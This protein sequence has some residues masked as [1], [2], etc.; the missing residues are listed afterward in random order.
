MIRVLDPKGCQT[1][2]YG[3]RVTEWQCQ[4]KPVV[5][6]DGKLYCKIHD[7]EY[8]K[9]KNKARD[10]K[11]NSYWADRNAQHEL[12]GAREKATLGLS[13]EELNQVTPDMIRQII[14]KSGLSVTISNSPGIR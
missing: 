11:F 13:L 3:D 5:T 1:R 4:K 9:A 6:R 8:I 10:E 7:P 14:R 12:S 2:I